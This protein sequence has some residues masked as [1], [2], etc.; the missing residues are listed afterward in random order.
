MAAAVSAGGLPGSRM[1][2]RQHGCR[3]AAR[4]LDRLNLAARDLVLDGTVASAGMDGEGAIIG[5]QPRLTAALADVPI[6]SS[7]FC[8]QRV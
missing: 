5:Q 6:E 2:V 4:D 8:R 7:C 3:S 1:R